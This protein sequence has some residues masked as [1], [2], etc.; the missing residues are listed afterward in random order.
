MKQ[1]LTINERLELD[2]LSQQVKDNL[3]HQA[4]EE[5]ESLIRNAMMLYP[6]APHPHNLY[7][8]LLEKEGN[9]HG[10]MCHYRAGNALESTYK[11]VRYNLYRYGEFSSSKKP[12][13]FEEDCTE[14][15]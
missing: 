6:H 13:Y 3:E 12:A 15:D 4:F 8:I 5:A 2:M 14:L 1:L 9:K 11:P 10:A 7:G